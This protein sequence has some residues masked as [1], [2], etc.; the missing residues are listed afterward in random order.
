MDKKRIITAVGH[1]NIRDVDVYVP[2]VESNMEVIQKPRIN[3][4]G[5]KRRKSWEF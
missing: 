1:I 4:R 2:I 5:K 3:K